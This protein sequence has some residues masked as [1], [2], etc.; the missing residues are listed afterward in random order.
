MALTA[1]DFVIEKCSCPMCGR[2]ATVYSRDGHKYLRCMWVD[3][4]LNANM[5]PIRAE[6]FFAFV[7]KMERMER[8]ESK[9]VTR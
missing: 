4:R 6:R 8:A 5:V 7:E 2:P 9:E 3:C 1:K